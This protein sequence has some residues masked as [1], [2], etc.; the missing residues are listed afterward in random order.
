[1]QCHVEVVGIGVWET[2]FAVS[3]YTFFTL[4]YHYCREYEPPHGRG[5]T[6]RPEGFRPFGFLKRGTT[7]EDKTFSRIFVSGLAHTSAG[8]VARTN[9]FQAL[10]R[11]R[12]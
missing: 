4:V 3:W 2:V 5:C 12:Y 11:V 10:Y 8:P 9:L 7:N 6:L 1:M